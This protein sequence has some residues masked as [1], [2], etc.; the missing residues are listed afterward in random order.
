MGKVLRKISF[1]EVYEEW[2]KSKKGELKPS[3]YVKYRNIVKSYL[4]GRFGDKDIRT[5]SYEEVKKHFDKLKMEGG[6]EHMG[7]A[8]T[9]R[10]IIATVIKAIFKYAIIKRNLRAA[11]LGD[12][13]IQC[14]YKP[15]RI[16]SVDEHVALE[17]ECRKNMSKKD[18][19][20]ILAMYTGLRIGELCAL[21]WEDIRFGEDVIAVRRTMYRLQTNDQSG[22]KTEIVEVAPKSSK[23]LRDIPIPEILKTTLLNAKKDPKA[24]VLSGSGKKVEPRRMQ[25]Y[26][27]KLTEKLDLKNVKCHTLRHTFATYCI[28]FGV[29]VK[30]LS[31][32]LGHASVQITMDR[33]V[34]PTMDMKKKCMDKLAEGLQGKRVAS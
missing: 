16:L 3:S 12:L 25:Y 14:A 34:H 28:E 13:K 23:S 21:K 24:Y 15:L 1:R 33:Y 29:D 32:V 27:K 19:G 8:D 4:I 20:I 30:T 9:T 26:L 11:E 2:L 10:R 5:I 22:K 7:L 6:R 17:N 31:A 18:L